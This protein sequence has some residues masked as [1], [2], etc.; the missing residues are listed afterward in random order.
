MFWI[1]RAAP[2]EPTA[3]LSIYIVWCVM[4]A[5]ISRQ[6]MVTVCLLN[7]S[8]THASTLT[9]TRYA[10]TVRTSTTQRQKQILN[11]PVPSPR[12]AKSRCC[13]INSTHASSDK[14]GLYRPRHQSCFLQ[15][16]QELRMTDWLKDLPP[17]LIHHFSL[18]IILS[19]FSPSAGKR[20]KIIYAWP[21]SH[22]EGFRLA[23]GSLAWLPL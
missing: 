4:S 23:G 13:C 12:H 17:S 5:G 16:R 14:S 10:W 20:E 11:L 3:E 19:L 18:F 2:T 8:T 15:T 6:Q 22:P 1:R 9:H 7:F 21:S